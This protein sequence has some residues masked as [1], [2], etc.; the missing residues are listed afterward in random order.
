MGEKDHKSSSLNETII[1]IV[2]T[3]HPKTVTQLIEL[4]Y[5]EHP[6]PPQEIITS[7]Y[8]LQRQGKLNFK[9]DTMLTPSTLRSHLLS[10]HAYWYWVTIILAIATTTIVLTVSENA[11]P[12]VYARYT[13]GSIF[14]LFLPGYAFIKALFPTKE[15]DN[16][17]RT[18]LSIG[19]SLALVPITGLILNYTPWGIRTT[20]VTLSLLA[21]TTVFATAAIIREHQTKLRKNQTTYTKNTLNE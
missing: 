16:I 21:L 20:P 5:Q 4:V 6:L 17:E 19:M 8:Y 11:Y 1:Q 13:L 18:A 2:K 14:V 12:I 10:S 3:K 9:Q 15:L 7:V